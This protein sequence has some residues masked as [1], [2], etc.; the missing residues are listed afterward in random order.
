MVTFVS[1]KIS[2]LAK[3]IFQIFT[4]LIP[5]HI[6]TELENIEKK[7]IYM[8]LNMITSVMLRKMVS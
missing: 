3:L 7:N 4:S 6:I 5:Y 2:A 1:F 8:R